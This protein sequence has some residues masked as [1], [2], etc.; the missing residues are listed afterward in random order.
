MV[1]LILVLA[2][3]AILYLWW[4]PPTRSRV[5][6]GGR[7]PLIGVGLLA[8]AYVISPIDLIPDFTP[9]GLF[10]DLIVVVTTG[11]WIYT[12]WQRRPRPQSRPDEPPPRARTESAW[13]PYRVLEIP[14][15][16]T[17]DEI[18]RAY[19]EQMKRYHPD[20]VGDLGEELQ[21]VAHRKTL[22]IQRAYTELTGS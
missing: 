21:Q 18:A 10:D 2:A 17:R 16:A 5:W 19:R 12:Q 14:R 9:V 11:W 15:G 1:R 4:R 6:R 3:V 22:E 20:R 7:L 8:L 13:D